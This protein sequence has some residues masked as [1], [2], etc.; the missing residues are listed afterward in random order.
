MFRV[1]VMYPNREDARFDFDY[2][3]TEH[4]SLV[5]RYMQP[6]GLLR[7]EVLKGIPGAAGQP[8][9]YLCIGDLYF[10]TADG[11]EQ[12]IAASAG[13]LRAD[14]SNFTNLT[15][16]RQFSEIVASR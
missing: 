8:P 12:G 2:Y 13:R 6:F 1:S 9:P 7:M 11:Y 5:H 16:L 4:V 15:P 10:E 14:I 3:C